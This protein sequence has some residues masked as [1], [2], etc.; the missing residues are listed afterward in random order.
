MYRLVFSVTGRPWSSSNQ[1]GPIMPLHSMSHQTVT[2]S[3]LSGIRTCTSGCV[4]AQNRMFCLLA[5]PLRWKCASSL[6]KIKSRILGCSLIH[7]VVLLQNASLSAFFAGV[8]AC[9]VCILYRNMWRFW[10][11]IVIMDVL[12]RSVYCDKRLLVFLGDIA[13]INFTLSM[14]GVS[15]TSP[16]LST[17]TFILILNTSSFL[18]F[19]QEV[20]NSDSGWSISARE[21]STKLSLCLDEWLSRKIGLYDF[22]P[23]L[24]RILNCRIHCYLETKI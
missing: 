7:W 13:K 1:Y 2:F 18:K 14:L 5:C 6:K 23:L 19:I 10:C 4:W 9:T 24:H 20:Q 15:S 12:N 11:I 22:D 16:R 3:T 8:W 21:T 17:V